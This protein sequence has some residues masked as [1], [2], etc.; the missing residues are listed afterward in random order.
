MLA[1]VGD[2]GGDLDL[3]L[4]ADADF[5]GD[6]STMKSTSGVLLDLTG[7][8]TFVPL[9]GVSKKQTCVSHS[10]PEA[11]IVAADLAVRAEGLPALDLWETVLG[12]KLQIKFREDIQAAIKIIECGKSET[13]RHMGRHMK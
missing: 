8:H 9:S 13:L 11:E 2:P 4:F 6:E 1:W 7:P 10:T 3:G 12:R 5:A